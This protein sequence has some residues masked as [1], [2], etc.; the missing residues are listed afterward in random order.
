MCGADTEE[1]GFPFFP[2]VCMVTDPYQFE[3][4]LRHKI[5]YLHI[6]KQRVL[7]YRNANP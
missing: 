7:K 1:H 3:S 6:F 2:L 4:E 5:H